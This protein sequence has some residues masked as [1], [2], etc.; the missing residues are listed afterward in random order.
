MQEIAK[1]IVFRNIKKLVETKEVIC[2]NKNS[3]CTKL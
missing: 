3:C 2:P 1:I